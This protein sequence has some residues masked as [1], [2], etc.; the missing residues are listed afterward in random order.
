[1]FLRCWPRAC[2]LYLLVKGNDV[3]VAKMILF[4][5]AKELTDY[6]NTHRI[7]MAYFTV[8]I[9]FLKINNRHP[10]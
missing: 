10:V 9:T 4:I 3:L 7:S 5:P 1:M 2:S 8:Y 6:V